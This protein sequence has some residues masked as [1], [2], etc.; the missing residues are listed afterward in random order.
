MIIRLTSASVQ[1][2]NNHIPLLTPEEA[3]IISIMIV[4]KAK[5]VT[6][7]KKL[8]LEIKDY[9]EKVI[10]ISAERLCAY[11]GIPRPSPLPPLFLAFG[12]QGASAQT[13]ILED[14]SKGIVI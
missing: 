5:L 3:D 13:K 1:T 10:K 6:F 14:G 12:N 2:D 11:L 7:S 8:N 9:Y 4:R